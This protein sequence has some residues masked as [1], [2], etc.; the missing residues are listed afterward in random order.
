M[1]DSVPA[2]SVDPDEF[3][4]LMSL[5]ST[6]VCIVSMGSPETG[7]SG[8]TANSFVSVSLDPML[9]CWSIQ[10]TSSQFSAYAEAQE[11]AISILGEDQHDIARRHASRGDT[12]LK[13]EDFVWTE[14][15]LPVVAGALGHVECRQWSLYPAGDHT[16]I[17]GEVTAIKAQ[18]GLRPLGFFGGRFCKIVD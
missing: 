11:F 17:F 5:F 3:R 13:V 18:H 14:G 8:F 12:Q 10:N 1:Q 16:M 9:V 7:P 2:Q 6:G 15:G 4:R